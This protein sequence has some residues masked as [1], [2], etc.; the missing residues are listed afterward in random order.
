MTME[1]FNYTRCKKCGMYIWEDYVHT[2]EE[3]IIAQVH[4]YEGSVPSLQTITQH[5]IAK[6]EDE[7]FLTLLELAE[8]LDE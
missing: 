1:T 2:E 6:I 7:H 5:Q 8:F 3:C 4:E